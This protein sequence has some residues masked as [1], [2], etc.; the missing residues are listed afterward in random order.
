MKRVADFCNRFCFR[1][2][3]AVTRSS[4]EPVACADGKHDLSEI[5]RE[6]DDPIDT[7]GQSYTTSCFVCDLTSVLS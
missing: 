7:F 4:N 3:I 1:R 2:I 6:R 5:W